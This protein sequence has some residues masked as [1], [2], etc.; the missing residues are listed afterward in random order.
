[1]KRMCLVLLVL[2]LSGC[3]TPT[4]APEPMTATIAS[5]ADGDTVLLASGDRVRLLQIDTPE[6][7][8]GLECYG[9]EASATLKEI[10]PVGTQVRLEADGATDDQDRYGRLLRYVFAGELNVNL[11]LVRR[12]AAAPYFYH[13]E[14]GRYA[15]ML[16]EAAKAAKAEGRGLW[17]ACFAELDPE[18]A[19]TTLPRGGQVRPA[20]PANVPPTSPAEPSEPS[21]PMADCHPS[22]AGAC[23]PSGADVDCKDIPT[24]TNIRVIGP[25]PYRLDGDGDGVAC[26]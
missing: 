5:Q 24:G 3:A 13:G 6:T 15:D 4:E 21:V 18:R 1:M 8:G 17:G 16:L 20:P 22:Y 23:L 25:D 2:V 19:V 9:K 7:H 14:R 26:R 12:G 11:E 10:L